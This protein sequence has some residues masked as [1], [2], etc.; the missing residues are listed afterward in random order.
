[1][2][3]TK[4][5]PNPPT[6]R[7]LLRIDTL[8]LFEGALGRYEG[9][10]PFYLY[11]AHASNG[12]VSPQDPSDERRV[13]TWSVSPGTR[14]PPYEPEGVLA[15]R[16]VLGG[17]GLAPVEVEGRGVFEDASTLETVLDIVVSRLIGLRQPLVR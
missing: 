10:T 11:P 14:V 4:T 13:Y 2:K 8:T 17:Y 5:V 6:W 12:L 7:D 16:I 3:L 1:M 15:A 9:M